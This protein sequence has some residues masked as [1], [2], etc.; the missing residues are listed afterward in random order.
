MGCGSH[1]GFPSLHDVSINTWMGKEGGCY[2]FS[3]II[4]SRYY[5]VSAHHCYFSTVHHCF[6]QS[7]NGFYWWIP[8]I[9]TTLTIRELDAIDCNYRGSYLVSDH[10][11]RD[12]HNCQNIF[13]VCVTSYNSG[14]DL[15]G[16]FPLYCTI[17]FRLPSW[18]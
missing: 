13:Q 11:S 15:G 3:R 2:Y 12:Y 1:H 18:N 14:I 4:P 9:S 17:F 7:V 10:L 16:F 8:I 5:L 6:S